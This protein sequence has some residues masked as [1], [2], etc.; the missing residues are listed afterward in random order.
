MWYLVID[1]WGEKAIYSLGTVLHGVESTPSTSGALLLWI[2]RQMFCIV[3]QGV[4]WHKVANG[5]DP[6]F[7][8]RWVRRKGELLFDD[9]ASWGW[10]QSFQVWGSAVKLSWNTKIRGFALR[11]KVFSDKKL[12]LADPVFSFRWV[13]R[14]GELPCDDTASLGWKLTFLVR[15]SAV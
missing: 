3:E 1:E 14:K 11:N 2:A 12:R 13:R 15:S 9:T 10:K 4:S 7:S 5:A 6:V 8:F